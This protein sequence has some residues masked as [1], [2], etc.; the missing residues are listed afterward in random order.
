M[1]FLGILSFFIPTFYWVYE[2]EN[3]LCIDFLNLLNMPGIDHFIFPDGEEMKE[4]CASIRKI[5]EKLNYGNELRENFER[6]RNIGFV[7]KLTYAFRNP[8]LVVACL[9]YSCAQFAFMVIVI[10]GLQRETIG[11]IVY[12]VLSIVIGIFANMY[13]FLVA[14][15][16]MAVIVVIILIIAIII[17]IIACLCALC[18]LSAGGS[19]SDS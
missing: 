18:L 17:A 3:G 8:F 11:T 19:R 14:A 5:A 15:F 1:P 7:K 12:Y 10:I 16:W 2:H 4:A 9:A 6:L 13:V